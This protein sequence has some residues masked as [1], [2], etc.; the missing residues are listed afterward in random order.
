MA[1]TVAPP[2]ADLRQDELEQ[3]LR[4]L[5]ER[6]PAVVVLSGDAGMG[7]TS[8]MAELRLR[9]A[10]LGWS[11]MRDD[12]AEA[13]RIGPH[14]RE[15]DFREAMRAAAG[16]SDKAPEHVVGSIDDIPEDVE[17]LPGKVDRGG[18]IGRA[19]ETVRR[20]LGAEKEPE[21]PRPR[22]RGSGID[23]LV[24]DLAL[25]S[26]LLLLIDHYRPAP[27]FAEWFEGSFLPDVLRTG[28][29]LVI[30]ISQ[31]PNSR[32]EPGA[33]DVIELGPLKGKLVRE[34]LEALP[35]LDPPL[36]RKELNAYVKKARNPDVL[37]CLLRVLSLAR[38]L[39]AAP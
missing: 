18:P 39:E 19:A 29:L 6:R 26:P 30:V 36:E 8:L 13:L 2:Q 28:A 34:A 4:I 32:L 22:P 38:K 5:A 12:A 35:A 37:A 7:K 11:T 33:S 10:A 3:L 15:R 20:H 1:V 16:R 17:L 23:Q 24:R 25:R 21:E 27:V 14:T 9:A 31:F